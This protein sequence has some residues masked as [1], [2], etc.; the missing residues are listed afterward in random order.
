MA[1]QRLTIAKISGRAA[2]LALDRFAFWASQRSTNDRTEWGPYQWPESVRS[3][4]D[5]WFEQLRQNSLS[6]P[7]LFYAEYNDYWSFCPPT[8]FIGEVDPRLLSI[9]ANRFEG[10]CIRLPLAAELMESLETVRISGQWNEDRLFA[11]LVIHAA[12]DWDKNS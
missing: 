11:S 3:E 7:V 4:A 10:F 8:R 1:S 9:Y 2:E 12:R 5:K 6:V